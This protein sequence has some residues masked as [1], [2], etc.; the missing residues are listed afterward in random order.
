MSPS[1]ENLRRPRS[2][3]NGSKACKG[4]VVAMALVAISQLVPLLST[5]FS[6]SVF[7]VAKEQQVH[8]TSA[9]GPAGSRHWSSAEVAAPLVG[10]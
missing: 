1:P 6:S 9:E 3:V 7:A 5:S 8:R 2:T 4:D 10:A